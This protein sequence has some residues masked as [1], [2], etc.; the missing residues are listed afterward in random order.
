MQE[1]KRLIERKRSVLVL[2]LQYCAENG[3]LAT[4]ERLQQEAGVAISKFEVVDNLDLLRIVQV[5][6]RLL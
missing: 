3:Y 4:A 2:M 6:P 1:E 5:R